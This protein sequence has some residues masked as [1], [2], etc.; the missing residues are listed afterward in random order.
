MN[1]E[2]RQMLIALADQ[3]AAADDKHFN[4]AYFDMTDDGHHHA[5]Y[6]GEKDGRINLARELLKKFGGK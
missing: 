5:Y 4:P 2:M 6:A 1:E 3:D